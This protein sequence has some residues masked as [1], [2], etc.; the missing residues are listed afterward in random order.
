MLLLDAMESRV[1][2]G[3]CGHVEL[4]KPRVLV[5]ILFVQSLVLF[6]S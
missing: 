2:R 3:A 6:D 5:V 1:A 4:G